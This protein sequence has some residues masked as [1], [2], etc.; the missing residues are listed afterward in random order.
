MDWMDK[1]GNESA[2]NFDQKISIRLKF[3]E[4]QNM[5]FKKSVFKYLEVKHDFALQILIICS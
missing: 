5:N 1:N 2:T 4:S 3:V